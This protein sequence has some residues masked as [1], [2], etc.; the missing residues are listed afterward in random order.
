MNDVPTIVDDIEAGK[1]AWVRLRDHGRRSW[2]EWLLVARAL[3]IGRREAMTTAKANRP[4]GTKYNAAMGEFLRRHGF[5]EINNQE[6]YRALQVLEHLET[7]ERWRAGLP[8]AKRR[9]TNHPAAIWH[10]WS[11]ATRPAAE[12]KP[13]APPAFLPVSG[14]KARPIFWPQDAVRRAHRAM[15]DSRSSDLLTLA[16]CALEGAIRDENDLHSL[17]EERPSRRAPANAAAHATA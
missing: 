5:D 13:K 17:L 8:E 3:D 7:I 14:N 12:P 6:R 15:L 4:F 11:R 16:R 2:S 1:A 10:A 9:R